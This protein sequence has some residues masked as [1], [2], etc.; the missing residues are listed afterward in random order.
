M[1]TPKHCTAAQLAR[2]AFAPASPS[3][4]AEVEQHLAACP[5]CT[6]KLAAMDRFDAT[7]YLPEAWEDSD[8]MTAGPPIRR[9]PGLA[10]TATAIDEERAMAETALAALLVSSEEF[11]KADATQ[12][13][14]LQTT[15]GVALLNQAADDLQKIDPKLA[16]LVANAAVTIA[17]KLARSA[18]LRYSNHLARAYR[19]RARILFL[20]G[21]YTDAEQALD[22]ADDICDPED[23]A[24]RWDT[25]SSLLIRANIC[26]E[27]ERLPDAG[28]FA[29]RAA[30]QF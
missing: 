1:T 17:T 16:L 27:T 29:A 25:A 13:A 5:E 21:R 15:G 9:S 26:L 24:A 6:E 30:R 14:A 23:P 19:E 7:P 2:Y 22:R 11:K 3:E 18:R 12:N 20:I 4:K 28:T 8:E 10:A